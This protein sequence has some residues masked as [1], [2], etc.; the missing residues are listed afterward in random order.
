[1]KDNSCIFAPIVLLC[2]DGAAFGEYLGEIL[3]TEGLPWF[4]RARSWGDVEAMVGAADALIIPQGA[5]V[6]MPTVRAW[7]GA[8]G[9]VVA[10]RPPAELSELA[11]LKRS[12]RTASELPLSLDPPFD[13]GIARAHGEVDLYETRQ[14]SGARVH[15]HVICGGERHP[16]VVSAPCGRGQLVLFAYDF[17]RSIAFT[18]QGNPEWTHGRGTDF[19]SNTFRPMDLFVRGN[20]AQTWLD[21][22][23]AFAPLADMQQRLLARL[24][25][26]LAPRPLPRVWYLPHATRTV[27]SVLGDSDGADPAVVSEQFDDVAA[28]GGC[29]SAF[30]IDYTVDRAD[31]ATIARWRAAGHEVSVHPDYGL[32]GDKSAPK[33]NT[34]LL[35]QGTILERFRAKFG[36]LPRTVRNHSITW[37]GFAEQ[38]EIER[39]LG[40][41]LNSS[42][43]YSSAFAKPSYGGPPVGYINGSGQPQKFADAHGRVLDIY[44]LAGQ[45]CDEM[46]KAQ[47]L[48]SD[49]EGAWRVTERI[50]E[51]SIRRWHS[52]IGLSF[53]PVTYHAN[54]DAKRW[55]RDRILPYAREHGLPLWSTERILD[56]ADARRACF[57]HDVTRAE[58]QFRG[59]FHAPQG[60]MGLTLMMPAQARGRKLARLTVNGAAVSGPDNELAEGRRRLVVVEQPE[61]NI[62]AAY[63]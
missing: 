9:V 41:R 51:A 30:L 55:L 43:V 20:G 44:Q 40:I 60:N 19:G 38:A 29:M 45:V 6:D 36:F 25:V 33:R 24:L 15:A 62:L 7:L 39:S 5:G 31:A 1:M 50:I 56:F 10:I 8:G 32:H 48:K 58:N 22:P 52:Y 61:S 28:A 59:E 57:M 13:A 35:T 46:L 12:G 26:S 18:R 42:Y 34:M 49:A 54:P 11:K 21:F 27:L 2:P 4:K 23:S 47:Y 16:A 3:Y 17:P 14:A 63:E 37:V 53:H